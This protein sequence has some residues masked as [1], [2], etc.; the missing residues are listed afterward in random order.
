MTTSIPNGTLLCLELDFDREPFVCIS[1]SEIVLAKEDAAESST[2]RI[3]G[4]SSMNKESKASSFRSGGGWTRK[5]AAGAA[6]SLGLASR[7]AE[8]SA[9]AVDPRLIAAMQAARSGASSKEA[10]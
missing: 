7:Q 10:V 2:E 8:Q 9:K 4:T 1:V 3:Q 6:G 5:L